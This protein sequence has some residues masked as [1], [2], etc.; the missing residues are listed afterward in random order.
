MIPPDRS[1]SLM[2][3]ADIDDRHVDCGG[4]SA[5]L[6]GECFRICAPL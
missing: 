4:A 6:Q 5:P 3:L 2:G 1:V